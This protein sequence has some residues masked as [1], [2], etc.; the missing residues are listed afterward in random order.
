M[1]FEN[2]KVKKVFILAI[3]L[4]SLCLPVFVFSQGFG[5]SQTAQ[6]AGYE[7]SR[8]D[9]YNTIGAVANVAFATVAFIFF[10]LTLYAGLRWVT[11]R[12]KEDLIEKAKGTM[13]S[14]IIGLIIVV[15]SYAIANFVISRVGSF[16]SESGCCIYADS[17]INVANQSD[18]IDGGAYYAAGST[19]C[20]T[21]VNC[22]ADRQ[23]PNIITGCCV[24]QNGLELRTM[25]GALEECE[26]EALKYKIQ[27][28]EIHFFDNQ[29]CSEIT[30]GDV[31]ESI[32]N[33]AL[34]K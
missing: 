4:L 26:E 11:A 7:P 15:L 28:T 31:L 24:F 30:Q 20:A 6:K 29:N 25:D 32:R 27:Y 5:L 23:D 10:G 3:F 8:G 1:Y 34:N 12:G 21:N 2:K 33:K 19:E 22:P 18:C 17:C 13:E 14:A 9:I 16:S